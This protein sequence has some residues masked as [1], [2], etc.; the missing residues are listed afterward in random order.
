MTDTETT[1]APAEFNGV[2]VQKLRGTIAKLT[3]NPALADFRFTARNSWVEGTA[4]RSTFHEWYGLN[5][6]EV[7]VDVDGDASR[8]DLDA[9]IAASTKRS[10]VFDIITAPTTV[11]VGPAF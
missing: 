10:A 3:D 5:H 1:V 9:L 11:L 4:T 7:A 2:P 6:V 8:E